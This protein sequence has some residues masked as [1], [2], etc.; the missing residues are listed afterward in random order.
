MDSKTPGSAKLAANILSNGCSQNNDGMYS[1]LNR[2][3]VGL[4]FC[5]APNPYILGSVPIEGHI[6]T[7]TG[8]LNKPTESLRSHVDIRRSFPDPSD[9]D[10][11]RVAGSMHR[12]RDDIDRKKSRS[13]SN[14]HKKSSS[15]KIKFS[16]LII[17]QNMN[18]QITPPSSVGSDQRAK[19]EIKPEGN[20]TR[21]KERDQYSESPHVH[22]AD[23]RHVNGSQRGT[24]P[25]ETS[26]RES[27]AVKSDSHSKTLPDILNDLSQTES[28]SM[29]DQPLTGVQEYELSLLEEKKKKLLLKLDKFD[30]MIHQANEAIV[31]KEVELTEVGEGD[32][33]WSVCTSRCKTSKQRS[34]LNTGHYRTSAMSDW[35]SPKM[36]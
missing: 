12:T 6:P 5:N 2:Q 23:Q 3:S 21:R 24:R 35:P 36:T 28:S 31:S 26:P 4:A 16:Q 15:R 8:L 7:P 30:Q 27:N 20:A 10:N 22:F 14:K 11:Q 34:S 18:E 1:S 33:S 9:H 13:R 29:K 25:Q 19:I 32:D 17:D